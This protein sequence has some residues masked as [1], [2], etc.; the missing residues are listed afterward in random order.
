MECGRRKSHGL[1]ESTIPEYGWRDGGNTPKSSVRK[2]G[3]W[4][5]I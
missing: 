3:T 5:K 2:A 4:A 1:I